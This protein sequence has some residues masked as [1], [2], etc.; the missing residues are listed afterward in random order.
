MAACLIVGLLGPVYVFSFGS[1]DS[2][3]DE[4]RV[5]MRRT[6]SEKRLVEERFGLMDA[7]RCL[8]GDTVD[9]SSDS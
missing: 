5:L 9:R 4:D 6:G 7:R 3:S 1:T 8:W 2:S